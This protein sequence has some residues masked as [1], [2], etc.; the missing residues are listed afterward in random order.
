M[1]IISVLLWC[2]VLSAGGCAYV[3]AYTY[4]TLRVYTSECASV[5]VWVCNPT[6]GNVICI[7]Y[8]TALVSV[9]RYLHVDLIS[10]VTE[11]QGAAR[12]QMRG[13][14]CRHPSTNRRPAKQT[15]A[16]AKRDMHINRL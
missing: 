4:I 12:Q 6:S 9:L 16:P 14:K 15:D 8:Q 10:M 3:C 5:C 7:F 13:R 2:N 11:G 1:L